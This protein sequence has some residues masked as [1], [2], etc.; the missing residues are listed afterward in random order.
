M[1]SPVPYYGDKKIIVIIP[2]YNESAI[3][4]DVVNKLY[5]AKFK[6]IIVVDDGSKNDIQ[7][8]LKDLPVFYLRHRVNL[9]QGAALQTGFTYARSLDA[10][11]VITFDAD[12]QHDVGDIEA[13]IQPVKDDEADVTMGSRFL[14]VG[15]NQVPRVKKMILQMA[16]LVNFLLTGL[17]LTDAHN[18]L[19]VINKNVLEKIYL[20]ENR[21]AH[22]SEFLFQLKKH[23]LRYKEVPVK[24]S[25]TNYAREKGQSPWDSIK[26]LFD[27]VLHKLFR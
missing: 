19:R 24:I 13:L 5:E 22:A 21:M 18:G 8:L 23:K 3:V 2:V 17:L 12:G 7:Q 16:R 27:L 11:I 6:T 26:I 15:N 20:T 4:R 1:S 10:D 9:G 14:S 25:Y